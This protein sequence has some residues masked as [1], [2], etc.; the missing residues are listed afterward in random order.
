MKATS[1]Q[2]VIEEHE[3]EEAKLHDG[4]QDQEKTSTAA[5]SRPDSEAKRK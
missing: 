5:P 1:V 3:Q 2:E 4:G